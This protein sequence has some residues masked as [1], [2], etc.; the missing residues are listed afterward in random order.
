MTGAESGQ[1]S[2]KDEETNAAA[3]AASNDAVYAQPG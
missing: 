1:S 2:N 3:S